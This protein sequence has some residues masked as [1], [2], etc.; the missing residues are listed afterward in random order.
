M[1]FSYNRK[2]TDMVSYI[3]ENWTNAVSYITENMTDAVSC[4]IE[5]GTDF[6]SFTI[7]NRTD[8]ISY[9]IGKSYLV[10]FLTNL[11]LMCSFISLLGQIHFQLKGRLARLLTHF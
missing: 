9:I 1:W 11:C 5:N 10:R 8:L 4:I 2:Q 6:V 7:E 3:I